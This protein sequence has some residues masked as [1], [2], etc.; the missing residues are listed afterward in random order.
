MAV[1][2][3]ESAEAHER[4]V[5]L[6]HSAALHDVRP[7]DV[8]RDPCSLSSVEDDRNRRLVYLLE[9]LGQLIGELQAHHRGS[10]ERS[11]IAVDAHLARAMNH[12]PRV[13]LSDRKRLGVYNELDFHRSVGIGRGCRLLK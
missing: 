3:T 4:G 5:E 11:V 13:F 12:P 10:V 6:R 2:P 7:E 8:L 1:G 9:S